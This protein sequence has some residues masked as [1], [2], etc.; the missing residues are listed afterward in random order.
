MLVALVAGLLLLPAHLALGDLDQAVLQPAHLLGSLAILLLLAALPSLMSVP[1]AIVLM[2]LALG[3]MLFVRLSFFGL[4]QFSGAGFT[5]EVFIHLEWK[6]IEVAWEQYRML[7]LV[8]LGVL[9]CVPLAVRAL[10]RRIPR[11]TQG[12]ALAL[13]AFA[14]AGIATARHGLPEWM[15]GTAAHAWFQPRQLDLP[16]SELQ[17]WRDSGLV[18]VDLPKKSTV[19]ASA[20]D[21][22]RNL[23][24]VY[25]ESVGLS[26]IEHPNYPG[27]MPN[28]AKRVKTQSLVPNL[29]ASGH[30]TIEGITNSQC[31]TLVPFER[32][33][34]SLAGF[35]GLAEEQPCLGDV[36][37]RAGYAQSYL[38]GAETSFAGKGNFLA[39]H[40]YDRIMGLVQWREMGLSPRRGGWGLGDPDLFTQ[41]LIELERLRSEGR[42]FNLTLLT[43]G[44]H[45]PGFTYDECKPYGSVPFIEA[46]HCTDQLLEHW[47][48]EL[49]RAGHLEDTLVVVTADHHVFPNPQ[50]RDLFG[51]AAIADKRLPLV[52]LGAGA[53]QAPATDTGASFDLAPTLLDLL[54]V[55]HDARFALGHSL[56]R[57]DARRDYFPTRYMDTYAGQSIKPPAGACGDQPPELPLTRCDK[58]ALMTLLRMQNAS[59]SAAS[60]VRLDCRDPARTRIRIPQIADAPLQFLIDGQ[61]HAPRF[62]WRA[63]ADRESQ[64]GLYVAVFSPEGALTE[65]RFIPKDEAAALHTRPAVSPSERMLLAWR[66]PDNASVPA[67]LHEMTEQAALAVAVDA[68]GQ[69]HPLPSQLIEGTSEFLLD[70][71]TCELLQ[72]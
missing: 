45:L 23:I 72:R 59:F 44:T 26:V 15:L 65:R 68:Q 46:L 70:A 37:A 14:L 53:T 38:G 56:L 43:I 52:V 62:T 31:G 39:A 69:A 35:D 24:L 30:I 36:L 1:L 60:A 50:M 55:E 21:A 63:R 17:R 13:A 57:P 11:T 28:L 18:T 34:D 58:A 27:L 66:D 16:A 42:P 71:K 5:D 22:P 61:D 8:L 2:T 29:H 54:D 51:D 41:S 47:L 6:S 32:G 4:V 25:L 3:L 33:S 12:I 64:P 49:E 9:V 10:A 40:G 67:W 7:C 19:R 20:A 48:G